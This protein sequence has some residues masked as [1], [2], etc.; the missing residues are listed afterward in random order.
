MKALIL[1]GIAVALALDAMA[2]TI[3]LACYL[4]G[5]DR[6]QTFR[7]ALHFGVFQFIMPVIGWFIGE[8][9]LRLVADYDHWIAFGLLLLIGLRMIRE[10]FKKDEERFNAQDPTRGWSLIV[11]ALATSQDALATGL[12]LPV[13]GI[14]IWLVSAV[15]GLM[16]FSLTVASS[17]VGPLLGKVFGRRAEVAGGVILILIG[18]KILIDHLG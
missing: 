10:S 2:V 14:N 6:R 4:N 3:G 16:A 5:L 1:L 7:L 12:S 8:N 18:L 9:L 11:L 15:I 17:R 13:L